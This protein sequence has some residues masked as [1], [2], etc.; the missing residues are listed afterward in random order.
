MRAVLLTC[1]QHADEATMLKVVE[2]PVKLLSGRVA[3]SRAVAADII[4]RQDLNLDLPQGL[5]GESAR[6]EAM[7]SITP[8]AQLGPSTP[9]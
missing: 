1:C 5:L 3:G 7:L 6:S 4:A 2:S 8:R 9:L